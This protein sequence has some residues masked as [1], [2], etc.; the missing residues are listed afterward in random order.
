M[1]AGGALRE[2]GGIVQ[3]GAFREIHNIKGFNGHDILLPAEEAQVMAFA[4]RDASLGSE[5]KL[6]WLYE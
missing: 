6:L 2:R 4:P 3:W 5:G 1:L